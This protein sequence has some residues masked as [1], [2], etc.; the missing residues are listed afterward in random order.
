MVTLERYFGGEPRGYFYREKTFVGTD[1]EYLEAKRSSST[2]FVSNISTSVRE[3]RIWELFLLCGPV[4]RV[5]MGLNRNTL[6]F[7]GFCFVEF[8]S[9]DSANVAVR[10]LNG[11][12]LEQSPLAIDKD[13]GFVDGRQYGRGVF[14]GRVKTDRMY[15]E[16]RHQRDNNKRRKHGR[17]L[18]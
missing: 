6:R 11:F 15:L 12:R 3:E 16:D 9:T 10:Y 5:V 7:C 2:V 13:Y 8:Y 14:G 4:R 18:R 17:H 1:E